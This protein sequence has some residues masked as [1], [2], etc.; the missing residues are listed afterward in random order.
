M[1]LINYTTKAG[2]A[3]ENRKKIEAVFAA[4]KTSGLKDFSYMVVESG[5][6]EFTHIVE[7]TPEALETMRAMPAFQEFSSTVES[8]QQT[9]TNRRD[10]TVVG[11]YGNLV[12]G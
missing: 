10:V 3:G 11:S 9:P 5:E 4:L 8:R 12:Q 7:S 1:R 2:Q 6:G